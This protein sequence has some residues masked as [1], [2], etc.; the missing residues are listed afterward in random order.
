MRVCAPRLDICS[1]PWNGL[2]SSTTRNVAPAMASAGS[3]S[4]ARSVAFGRRIEAEAA[5]D[6]DGG[7]EDQDEDGHQG[8]GRCL[9]ADH[10][11]A[12]VRKLG[13]DQQRLVLEPALHIVDG[14]QL[15][16]L[17]LAVDEAV[18]PALRRRPGRTEILVGPALLE[19]AGGDMAQV[20][21]DL[22]CLGSVGLQVLIEVDDRTHD[23]LVLAL[24]H[25]VMAV[26]R[27]DQQAQRQ[28]DHRCHQPHGKLDDVDGVAAEVMLRQ[29]TAHGAADTGAEQRA[30]EGEHKQSDGKHGHRLSSFGGSTLPLSDNR[31]K[32]F[33][34][35]VVSGK[36][37]S[38]RTFML[39]QPLLARQAAAVA[40]QRAVRA[41]DAMAGHDDADRVLAVGQARRAH[42]LGLADA[43][44][45]LGVADGLAA[46]DLAQ[47]P[48]DAL[49]ERGA[50]ARRPAARRSR[51]CRP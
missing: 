5:E 41:D 42:R 31:S 12:Q 15:H 43:P 36:L 49:L 2:F 22:P 7:E 6:R 19:G 28:R 13:A 18:R 44:R 33:V 47:R 1:R 8:R 38:Q 30:E 10:Q 45:Q 9:L 37:R 25:G 3:T 32:V 14:L 21:A 4:I 34:A 51:R 24:D 23:L 16:E 20:R 26:C 11:P 50:G 35:E 27:R 40:G 46:P 17:A 39:E 29:P 48:P